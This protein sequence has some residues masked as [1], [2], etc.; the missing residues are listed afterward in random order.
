MAYSYVTYT[1]DGVTDIFAVTFPYIIK[2]HVKVYVDGVLQ[3]QDTHYTWPTAATIQFVGAYVPDVDAVVRIQRLTERDSRLVVFADAS[4]LTET[5]LNTAFKQDFYLAQ[6]AF[7]SVDATILLDV[8][9]KWDAQSKVI[10]NVADPTDPHDAMTYAS[11]LASVTAAAA[12]AS[13]ASTSATAASN[14]ASAAATSAT[15]AGTSAT[16]AATSATNAG[17]SATAAEASATSASGSATAAAASETSASGSATT[18]SGHATTAQN[19]AQKND[20]YA[21]GSDNSAKSWAIGG[22][23]NGIPAAGSAKDWA[24]KTGG[25]VDGAEYSAKYHAQAAAA[26]ATAA[27]ASADAAAASATAADASA[28]AAAADAATVA[29]IYDSFDDRYLG[30]KSSAPTLDNDGNALLTGALYW[31]STTNAMKVYTGSAWV[32]AAGTAFTYT[33]ST[34]APS[35]GSDGDFWFEREA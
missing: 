23:G 9:D 16:N 10:K 26:S 7:D 33:V 21:S 27:D 1:G 4:Q 14:S 32:A 17:N 15:N 34:S 6:E 29:T 25:T 22:T 3:T 30:S 24:T 19:Y 20:G 2:S 11:A 12:S 13:A 28:D 31:D 18:A 5:D 35:G 8:D